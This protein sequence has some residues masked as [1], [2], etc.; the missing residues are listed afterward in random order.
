MKKGDTV[1]INTTAFTGM[2]KRSKDSVEC[3]VLEI[4]EDQIHVAV[5]PPY[6]DRT[7]WVDKKWVDGPLV[8]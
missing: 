4:K 8:A 3:E 6:K 1:K 5:K 2:H 7:L